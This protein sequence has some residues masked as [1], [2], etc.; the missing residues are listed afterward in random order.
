MRALCALLATCTV[1]VACTRAPAEP[2]PSTQQIAPA[3]PNPKDAKGVAPCSLLNV[4]QADALGLDLNLA[5]AGTTADLVDCRWPSV[6]QPISS[7]SVTVDTNPTRRGLTDT[8]LKRGDFRIFEPLLV[9]GYPAV[10]AE[11]GPT[12]DCTI[13]VGLSDTQ[14]MFVTAHARSPTDSC[15]LVKQAIAAMLTNLP[16]QR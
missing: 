11:F 4:A 9:E 8:Y 15:G 13:E 12:N 14:D 3:V 10:R 2:A 1:L 7:L 16:L 5:N 6:R